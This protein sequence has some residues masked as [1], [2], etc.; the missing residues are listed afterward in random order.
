MN[1][2]NNDKLI[3]ET[4]VGE[5]NYPSGTD[6][7]DILNLEFYKEFNRWCDSNTLVDSLKYFNDNIWEKH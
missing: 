2:I 7:D 4:I 1:L 6:I 5:N 3:Q